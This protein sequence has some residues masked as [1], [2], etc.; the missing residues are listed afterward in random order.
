MKATTEVS[1]LGVV[2]TPVEIVDFMIRA[3]RTLMLPQALRPQGPHRSKDVQHSSNRSLG[4]GTYHSP[5]S[6]YRTVH[7]RR[8]PIINDAHIDRK[9]SGGGDDAPPELHATELVLL[10]YYVA[11]LKIEAGMEAREGFAGAA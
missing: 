5:N 11:A 10:A 6:H 7:R 3:H 1:R 2:Y 4:T 8:Q 9:F